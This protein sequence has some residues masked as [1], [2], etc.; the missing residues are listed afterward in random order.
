M[1]RLSFNKLVVILVFFFSITIVHSDP[2]NGEELNHK[3]N[4]KED[5]TLLVIYRPEIYPSEN[6]PEIMVKGDD[7]VINRKVPSMSYIVKELH[8]GEY[9]VSSKTYKHKPK[10]LSI[11]LV[12]GNIH[13][14]RISHGTGWIDVWYDLLISNRKEFEDNLDIPI[15]G[16]MKRVN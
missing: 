4:A 1:N 12:N 3:I 5:T 8:E 2:G 14:L 15:L 13:Y 9:V 10:L 6:H 16:K 11:S 7:V